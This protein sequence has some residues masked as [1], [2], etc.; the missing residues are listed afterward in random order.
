[1]NK[2]EK[3]I[4]IVAVVVAICILI[5][6]AIAKNAGKYVYYLTKSGQ[7]TS[8]ELIEDYDTFNKRVSSLGIEER[9]ENKIDFSKSN[10]SEIFTEEYFNDKKVAI[11]STHEDTT[12]SYMYSVDKVEYNSDK[13]TA[14][15]Y[16]TDKAGEYLGPLKNSW[17]NYMLVEVAGT[18]TNVDFVKNAE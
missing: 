8:N 13:T 10:I 5:Y 3:I 12:K 15:I 2:T 9:L 16:Y 18:V 6:M 1:M 4:I 11:I 14:T 7:G 17:Y